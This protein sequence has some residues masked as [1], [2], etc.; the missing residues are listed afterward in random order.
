MELELPHGQVSSGHIEDGQSCAERCHEA[1]C[2]SSR[3]AHRRC[4][5]R[6]IWQ[7]EK[8]ETQTDVAQCADMKVA[9]TDDAGY[10]PVQNSLPFW[11]RLI[12]I[13]LDKRRLNG[14]SVV[15][16]SHT[17]YLYRSRADL[18]TKFDLT[19]ATCRP[20]GAKTYE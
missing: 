16:Q 10:M 3:D 14:C 15:V 4:S 12:R 19:G 17:P 11:C 9:G 6:Q 1:N 13:V 20:C 5:L 8:C 7:H 2:Y 18:H